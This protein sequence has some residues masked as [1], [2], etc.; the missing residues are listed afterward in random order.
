MATNQVY[1]GEVIEVV[2]SALTHPTRDSNLVEANDPVFVGTLVGVALNSAAANTDTIEVAT[3]GVWDLTANAVT[4]TADSAISIG[5]KLYFQDA[6][7][8]AYQTLTSDATAPSDGDTVT[9]DGEVYTYRTNIRA[10]ATLTSDA[11]APSDDD[12]VT[13]GD[14][15]YTFKTALTTDPAAVPYEVLIGISAAVALD[16]LKSAI[17]GTSGAG[18]T[19]GTG[20]AAHTQVTA[21]TNTNTTQEIQGIAALDGADV[22]LAEA[23]SHLSWSGAHM[24]GGDVPGA[25]LIGISAAVALDNLKSAINATAGEGTTYGTGTTAHSTVTAT[26]NANTTQIVEA[27]TAGVA[28]NDIAVSEASS[29]LSWGASTLGG[30]SSKGA[31]TKTSADV[32]FGVALETL[33]AGDTGTIKV[34]IKRSMS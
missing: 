2:E 30:G 16:N 14:T 33:A 21:E 5:D 27:A 17:N 6:E 31:L 8:K 23:S 9:I 32:G 10:T 28:G 7:T 3:E 22:D 12:T 15:V 25:V 11:T 34:K 19:Y 29:H 1:E 4:A 18:T 13:I 24:S 26:T 20:T